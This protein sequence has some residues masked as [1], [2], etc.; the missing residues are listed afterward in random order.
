MKYLLARRNVGVLQQFAWSHVL[1]GLDFDGTLAPIAVDLRKASMRSATRRALIRMAGRY[2]TVVVS[3]R[4]Q[5]DV[6]R[7]LKGSPLR[8]VAGNHG[9]EPW[10]DAERFEKVVAGWLPS[11]RRSLAGRRGVLIENKRYSIAIHYRRSR[12]KRDD[13]LAIQR[14]IARL[15]PVRVIGGKQVVNVLPDGAPHKG[16]ALERLR[17]RLGCD[18]AIFVGDDQ[19]DEDVFGLDEP[20]RLLTIRV[21]RSQNSSADYFIRN[22]GETDRLLNVLASYRNGAGHRRKTDE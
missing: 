11:L 5:R 20:G 8:A 4:A 21:G 18:T 10:D 1:V 12:R 22:Q 15:G 13:R 6:A 9:L 17:T 7:R 2:P 14:A 16:L 3:G 19:T